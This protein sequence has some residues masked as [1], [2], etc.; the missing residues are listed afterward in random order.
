[1]TKLKLKT[2][3]TFDQNVVIKKTR[4]NYFHPIGETK[5]EKQN[6][7]GDMFFLINQVRVYSCSAV[8]FFK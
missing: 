2:H 5:K 3:P 8:C 1:M 7:F 6:L 4:K